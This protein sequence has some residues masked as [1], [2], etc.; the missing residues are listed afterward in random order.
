MYLAL[1]F[2]L[3][4]SR[5][6]LPPNHVSALPALF[7]ERFPIVDWLS[8]LLVRWRRSAGTRTAWDASQHRSGTRLLCRRREER[9]FP[10]TALETGPHLHHLESKLQNVFAVTNGGMYYS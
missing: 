6:R 1:A 2:E 3:T 7:L 5:T 8:N 10:M 4:I 9:T